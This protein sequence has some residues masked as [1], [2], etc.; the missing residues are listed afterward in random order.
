M[1]FIHLFCKKSVEKILKILYHI[2]TDRNKRQNFIIN[3]ADHI[4]FIHPGSQK[5]LIPHIPPS[6]CRQHF[7]HTSGGSGN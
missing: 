5:L 2:I 7:F 1:H 3:Y 4:F 6:F